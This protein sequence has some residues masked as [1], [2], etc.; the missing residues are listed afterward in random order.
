MLIDQRI[1]E[2]TDILMKKIVSFLYASV[3]KD[4]IYVRSKNQTTEA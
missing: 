4:N 3:K 1:L 2:I